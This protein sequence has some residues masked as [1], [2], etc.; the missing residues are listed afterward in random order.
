MSRPLRLVAGFALALLLT[1]DLDRARAVETV[2]RCEV[3]QALIE[4]DPALT[5]TAARLKGGLPLTI[6]AIG[7]AS[8]A[9]TAAGGAAQAYPHWLQVALQRRHPESAITVLNRGVPRETTATMVTRFAKDVIPADPTLVIWET[10]TVDA[11]R[12]VAIDDFAGALEAGIAA[13]RHHKY[14]IMLVDMQY[15]PNI[16]TVM[17]FA[18]YLEALHNAADIENVYLFRR[19]EIM[20]YWSEAGLFDLTGIPRNMRPS[21]AAQIYR[22]LGESLAR[23]VDHGAR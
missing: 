14:D 20:K 19:F 7:D 1:A 22:C 6:V 4:D 2:A 8:T 11:V 18:P 12:G 15:N 23:A 17:D 10:G 21:I 13:L 3:P 5:A 9:G 16:E